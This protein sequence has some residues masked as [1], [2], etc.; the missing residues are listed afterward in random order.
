MLD[1]LAKADDGLILSFFFDFSDTTKQTLDGMLR[2]LIFQIYRSGVGSVIYLDYL[3]KAHQHGGDQPTTEVLSDTVFKMLAV[4]KKVTIALDALDQSKSAHDVLLWIKDM[5]FRPE[6]VHVQLLYTSRPYTQFLRYIPPLIGWQNCLPLDKRAIKS[7][8]RTFHHGGAGAW[9]LKNPVFQSWYF[10]TPRQL[11]LPGHPGCGKMVLGAT[12]LEYLAN[13]NNGLVLCFYFDFSDTTRQTLHGMLRFLGKGAEVNAQGPWYG[14]ALQTASHEDH[15]EFLSLLLDSGADFNAHGG[16]YGNPPQ[17]VSLESH[18]KIVNLLVDNGVHVNTQ[19]V[20]YGNPLHAASEK[21][22]QKVIKLLFDMRANFNTLGF[23]GFL[24]NPDLKIVGKFERLRNIHDPPSGARIEE[25]SSDDEDERDAETSSAEAPVFPHTQRLPVPKLL[26]ASS[27][28]MLEAEGAGMEE[29]VEIKSN[30][31]THSIRRHESGE[32]SAHGIEAGVYERRL[33]SIT[34]S[35]DSSAIDSEMDQTIIARKSV[36]FSGSFHS[37]SQPSSPHSSGSS[38]I[39]SML[40]DISSPDL[41]D[42]SIDSGIAGTTDMC[43]LLDSAR[44]FSELDQLELEIAQILDLRDAS[45]P[46]LESLEDCFR[47]LKNWQDALEYLQSQGFCGSI[48]NFLVEDKD[49][50]DVACACH[51]SLDQVKTFSDQLQSITDPPYE[52]QIMELTRTWTQRILNTQDRAFADDWMV[53]LRILCMILSVGLLSFSGS[54][55]CRF[56]VTLWDRETENICIGSYDFAFRPRKLACLDDFIGGP[57][58]VLSKT[59][60]P[61]EMNDQPH[62]EDGNDGSSM[63]ESMKVSYKTQETTDD[64]NS[65]LRDEHHRQRES[66]M[67]LSCT[68]Q[69]LEILWGPV[70]LVGGT[71]DEAPVIRTERGFIVPVSRQPQPSEHGIEC[72]WTT[73]IPVHLH[74]STSVLLGNTSKILIGTTLDAA[75]GLVVNE[76]CKSSIPLIQQQIACQL[77]YPGTCK[78]KYV[79]DG[80]DVQL[81][82][83]Q[84]ATAGFVKKYK[85]IPKRT[86]KAMLVE[87]CAKPDTQLVPLLNLWVGLE[88]SACTGNA[89]RVRLWDALR[90][91]QAG[92]PSK[93]NLSCCPHAVGSKSCIASCWSKWQS[94][95]EI[96]SLGVNLGPN[97]HLDGADARRIIIHSILALEHSGV[98]SDGNLQVC[99]PFSHSPVNYPILPSSPNGSHH[100]FRV[101]KDSRDTSTFAVFSQIC[102]EF[103]ERGLVRSFSA[104]C[105]DGH[106]K[107]FQ[108]ILAT[109]IVTFTKDETLSRL[110]QGARFVVGDAHL[111]VTKVVPDQVAIIAAVSKNPLSPLRY[112]LREFLPDL[113]VFEFKEHVRPDL[114][115]DISLPVFAY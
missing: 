2:S 79:N 91:S 26:R 72:H 86:L 20:L 102:L 9:L 107:P 24:L 78:S 73:K 97:K 74:N 13:G 1:H 5:V 33:P 46:T 22:Y 57:A 7:D 64:K 42:D 82:G 51:I 38:G 104:P 112:R 77:Q 105:R 14:N 96:D 16:H 39:R 56:D 71:R 28:P 61:A 43:H 53:S 15:Q 23:T 67:K 17:A 99:W 68:V 21:R 110:L 55:V 85:R 87:D 40:T 45:H 47:C 76:N 103:R 109:R 92:A 52:Q 11:W 83:G 115:T 50:S 113:G 31:Q 59:H 75:I 60:T 37:P 19:E 49:Q 32:P 25:L 18:Q 90:L 8:A 44:Y 3:F 36:K 65:M 106:C 48:M 27:C 6:L 95:D 114:T 69:D 10:G 30:D 84:Y 54:H 12:V 88:V 41:D 94:D 100:W 66:G 81:V 34:G 58:W 93:N 108:T 29:R 35:T 98:D 111:S 62:Q 101:V 4:Q 70:W 63:Q 89:Q 80:F